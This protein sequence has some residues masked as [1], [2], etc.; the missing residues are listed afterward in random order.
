MAGQDATFTLIE[1][2]CL[3]WKRGS[4]GCGRGLFPAKS[5]GLLDQARDKPE[6]V[7][8]H[9]F[10][11]GHPDNFGVKRFVD[12]AADVSFVFGPLI[13]HNVSSG[14]RR[15]RRK[16]SEKRRREYSFGQIILKSEARVRPG[17]F[18]P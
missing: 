17:L 5:K 3:D 2:S 1:A 10:L 4:F 16:T 14:F 6:L 9:S 15:A 18:T 13:R 7:P 12:V 11:L 8:L